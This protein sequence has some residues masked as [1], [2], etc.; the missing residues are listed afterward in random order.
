MWTA[1]EKQFYVFALRDA[2]IKHLPH[3]WRIGAL[4]DIGCQI[5]QSLKKWDFLPEW[6]GIWS[7]VHQ[8]SMHM[9][10]SGPVN[11]GTTLE[12]MRSGVFQMEKGVSGFGSI[13][14]LLQQF[15]EQWLYQSQPISWQ[16]Q[17]QGAHTIDRIL[18]LQ[19]TLDAQQENL[20]DLIKEG[21]DMVGEDSEKVKSTKASVVHLEN[22]IQKKVEELKLRDQVAAQKLS[23]LK[24]DK[25]ITLQLNLCVLREQLLQKLRE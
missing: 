5:D 21:N 12:R 4:Y 2:L 1:G 16:S 6:L 22:N 18:S 23:K 11:Y 17:T 13:E 15:K 3:H 14:Y 19:S 9:G 20:Q 7:G 8:F 10:T 24:K 25:W